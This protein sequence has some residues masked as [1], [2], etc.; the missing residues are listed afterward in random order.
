M[1]TASL[2]RAGSRR[3]DLGHPGLSALFTILLAL[4]TESAAAV[5]WGSQKPLFW[6]RSYDSCLSSW[7]GG[8]L[9]PVVDSP[10]GRRQFSSQTVF[11]DGPRG[12]DSGMKAALIRTLAKSTC[13]SIHPATLSGHHGVLVPT[14]AEAL[15]SGSDK[16]GS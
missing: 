10:F 9:W 15:N 16:P 1:C 8:Q 6:R 3:L 7:S 13:P 5:L 11:L 12:R 14:T 4:F 2:S